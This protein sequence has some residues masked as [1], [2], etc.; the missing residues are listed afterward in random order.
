MD[1]LVENIKSI[2]SAINDLQGVLAGI[3]PEWQSKILG[4][5]PEGSEK[6]NMA[7][8][9]TGGYTGEWGSSGKLAVLHQ[10][11]LVLNAFD[12]SNIL[13][14]VDLIR[15]IPSFGT[16]VNINHNIDYGSLAAVGATDL[17]QQVHIDASFPNVQSHTEIELAL[18]NLINS[19]SQY[20]NRKS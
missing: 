7:G 12:T 3:D 4:K 5:L 6:S 13:K 19:A 10:K 18:N 1:N 20:V 8:Y 16:N 17:Q 2:V 11:E 15:N 9:D 14:A